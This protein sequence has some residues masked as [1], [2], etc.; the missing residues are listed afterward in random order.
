MDVSQF[1]RGNYL[2][3]DDVNTGD[4]VIIRS[5]GRQ[6]EGFGG[7]PAL[8]LDIEL[9]DGAIVEATLNQKSVKNLGEAWGTESKK[10]INRQ[11]I[12]TVEEKIING[13]DRKII[14]Y[15]PNEDFVPSEISDDDIP[16]I[17]SKGGKKKLK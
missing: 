11:A 2:T 4:I 9:S 13:E 14:Y 3:P 6:K 1:M 17:E 12:I 16:V 7:K 5:E 8:A 15:E 10:W